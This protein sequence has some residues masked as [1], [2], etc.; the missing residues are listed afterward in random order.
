MQE[1][2]FLVY[3]RK[4]FDKMLVEQK[5]RSAEGLRGLRVVARSTTELRGQWR[6]NRI[7]GKTKVEEAERADATAA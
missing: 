7:R 5:K 4:T 6:E 1:M 2:A 3:K